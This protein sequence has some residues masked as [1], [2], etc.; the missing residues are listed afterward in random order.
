[1]C[2]QWKPAA[3]FHNSRRNEYTYCRECRNAY[4]RMYYA[5]RGKPPRDARRRA[6]M[7]AA[8]EWMNQMKEGLPCADCGDTFPPFVMHWDH[9][10]GFLKVDEISSML[11]H[12][13]REAI[14]EE[15]TKCELVCAN[16]HVMRTVKRATRPYLA[17]T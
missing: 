3:D 5:E 13:S 17:A 4:D 15:L 1:M 7:D 11:G 8:R 10:P 14:L 16:C 12:R 2:Q 9:L 6:A